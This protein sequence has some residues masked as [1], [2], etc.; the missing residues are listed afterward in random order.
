MFGMEG[1]KGV[2]SQQM[3]ASN[4]TD[5]VSRCF[6]RAHCPLRRRHGVAASQGCSGEEGHS[7]ATDRVE[8]LCVAVTSPPRLHAYVHNERLYFVSNFAQARK[9][10]ETHAF[11]AFRMSCNQSTGVDVEFRFTIS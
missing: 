4:A 7:I 2:N 10:A 3:D 6:D 11:V 5:I 8:Y 1:A 9:H